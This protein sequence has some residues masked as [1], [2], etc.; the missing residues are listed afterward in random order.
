MVLQKERAA[1][2]R[3]SVFSKKK[4]L[5]GLHHGMFIFQHLIQRAG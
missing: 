1:Q 4:I 5:P 3:L 2:K